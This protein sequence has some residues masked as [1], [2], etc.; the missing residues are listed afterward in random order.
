MKY[1][2]ILILLFASTLCRA[3]D[4]VLDFP[5]GITWDEYP[6]PLSGGVLRSTVASGVPWTV[7]LNNDKVAVAPYQ[8]ATRIGDSTTH[9]FSNF[10]RMIKGYNG[11][12]YVRKIEN[13]YLV[14]YNGWK[15]GG[16]V[17]W[18]NE[19]AD[20]GYIVCDNAIPKAIIELNGKF[21]V[22]DG[23]EYISRGRGQVIYLDKNK[24]GK[25]ASVRTIRLPSAP[26]C[27]AQNNDNAYILT[28]T[29]VIRFTAER[30]TK[31]FFKSPVF[32]GMLAPNSV[33]INNDNLY[34]GLVG[35][36]LSISNFTGFEDPLNKEWEIR[37]FKP[38]PKDSTS[39]NQL[40]DK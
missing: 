8:F 24:Q 11:V 17:W 33:V 28:E 18:F 34:I 5:Q 9:T 40:F 29:D 1:L 32:W 6:L 20:S 36:I 23:H 21:F 4:T 38:D 3:E 19:T 30:G 15:D 27:V 14:G 22:I 2:T 16:S 10:Q 7:A 26:I 31:L 39:I 12:R 13:G 35:G 37:W 25:W